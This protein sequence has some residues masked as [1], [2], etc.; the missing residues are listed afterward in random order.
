MKFLEKEMLFGLASSLPEKNPIS[1]HS[2]TE[3]MSEL[4]YVLILVHN[5]HSKMVLW[6]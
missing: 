2:V 5:V 6:Y 3:V 1:L 4:A